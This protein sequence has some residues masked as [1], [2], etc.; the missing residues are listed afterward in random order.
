MS[1]LYL[2]NLRKQP[3]DQVERVC[4]S[5]LSSHDLMYGT[6]HVTMSWIL[7]KSR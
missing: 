6:E 3:K 1:R 5:V 4:A 2:H 7:S